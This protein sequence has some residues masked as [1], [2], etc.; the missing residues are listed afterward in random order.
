MMQNVQTWLV[1]LALVFVALVGVMSLR[2]H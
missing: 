2:L 1:V